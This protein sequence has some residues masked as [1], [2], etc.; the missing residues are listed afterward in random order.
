MRQLRGKVKETRK[1]KKERKM[2][3]LAIQNQLKTIVIPSV[4]VLALIII[5]FVYFKTRPVAVEV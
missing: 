1:Q 5:V 2:E 3:N 4:C